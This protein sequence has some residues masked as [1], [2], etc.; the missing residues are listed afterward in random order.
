MSCFDIVV[1]SKDENL[2]R[3]VKAM[4]SDFNNYSLKDEKPDRLILTYECSDGGWSS[5]IVTL[6]EALEDA[7]F[8]ERG[9][10]ISDASLFVKE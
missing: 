7:G 4:L 6:P 9:A 5:D 3:G 8:K 10:T 1:V 2:L